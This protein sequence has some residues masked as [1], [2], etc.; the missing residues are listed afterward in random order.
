MKLQL[1]GCQTI[2]LDEIVS[3]KESDIMI[4]IEHNAEIVIQDNRDLELS[5]SQVSIIAHENSF[6][7]YIDRRT[8]QNFSD[9][10]I[11]I[12][13]RRDARIL[14]FK[15]NTVI[16]SQN[17][18]MNLSLLD[19][20]SEIDV[21]IASICYEGQTYRLQSFQNH[22]SSHSKSSIAVK[23]V[24]QAHAQTEYSGLIRIEKKAHQSR[25]FQQHRALLMDAGC[26][27]R[28]RPSLEV[29]ADDVQCGHGSA[30]GQLDQEQVRYLISRGIQGHRAQ[31]LLLDAFFY[32]VEPQ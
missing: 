18:T 1:A 13:A 29:L 5:A 15:K 32:D 21:R 11:S 28:A 23:E 25:A 12:S 26:A 24:L 22:T 2:R 20:G 19:Q 27:A 8:Y 16:K 9:E 30:I 4:S 10:T 31:D 3:C 6:L 7:T 17:C 14:L